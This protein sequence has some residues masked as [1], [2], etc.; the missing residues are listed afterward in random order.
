MT[1]KPP[2]PEFT[3][4][5][6]CN[7]RKLSDA[8][9]AEVVRLYTTRLPDGTWMGASTIARRYGVCHPTIY[10][11]LGLAGIT[12][13]SMSEAHRGKA[14]RPVKNLPVGNPP[15]CKCGCG[16]L[17]EWNRRKNRWNRYVSGHYT[18]RGQ[19]SHTWIDGRSHEP[20]TED[21]PAVSLAI[22]RRD[23]FKCQRCHGDSRRLHVHH[24]DAVKLNNDH[25]NLITLCSSCHGWVHSQMRKGVMPLCQS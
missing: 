9:R 25:K 7:N 12:T 24:I 10:R 19:Q 14:C 4:G 11:I 18:Q 23:G 1:E 16:D 22:R 2:L 3:K 20:Y 13:R 21:W 5:K 17:V 15:L 8:D 6:G